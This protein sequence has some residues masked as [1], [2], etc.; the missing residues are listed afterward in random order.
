MDNRELLIIMKRYRQYLLLEKSLSS[1]TLEAYI[2]DSDK[3]LSFL[4]NEK[5]YLRDIT[6][7]NLHSFAAA[8]CDIGI[9]PRSQAR[10]ISGIKSFFRFLGLDGYVTTAPSD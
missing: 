6:I 8:L 7:D 4:D 3:L 1:N 10:I 2:E 9:S 5:I